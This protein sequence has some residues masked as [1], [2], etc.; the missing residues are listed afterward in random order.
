MTKLFVKKP[1]L[2][3]VTI[4]IVITIGCVSLSNMQTNLLPDMELP[5]LAVI[6]TDPGASPEEVEIKVVK[7]TESALGVI[8]GVK[9][10]ISTSSNNY[11]MVLLE[12]TDD[13]NLDSALVRV[14]QAVNSIEYPDECGK[15]NILEISL[16]MMATIYANVNY[17]DKDIKELTTFS[18]NYVQPYLERQDGV[19]SVSATGGIVNT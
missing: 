10:V 9:N 16:D 14:S 1:F 17:A 19:A 6:V 4:I 7:P 12:F 11:G 3:L 8:S 15:P 5:Y 13:I 18:E 2:T